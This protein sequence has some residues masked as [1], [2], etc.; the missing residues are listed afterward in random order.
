VDV[1]ATFTAW[2]SGITI[3]PPSPDQVTTAS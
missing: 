3:T 1:T 2:N